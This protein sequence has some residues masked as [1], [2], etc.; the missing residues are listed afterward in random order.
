MNAR[1]HGITT[2]TVERDDERMENE[3]G[4]GIIVLDGVYQQVCR[5]DF[6]H[7]WIGRASGYADFDEGHVTARR[8]SSQHDQVAPASGQTLKPS[9]HGPAVQSGDMGI[10]AVADN[11]VAAPSTY[12]TSRARDNARP[13]ARDSET[14]FCTARRAAP[15]AADASCNVA[16][17]I[18]PASCNL[19]SAASCCGT[20]EATFYHD[21]DQSV[22]PQLTE[23]CPTSMSTTKL[24]CQLL[25][26]VDVEDLAM[27]FD[28]SM[29]SARPFPTS[30]RATYQ[31]RSRYGQS[32][33]TDQQPRQERR[34]GPDVGSAYD[35]GSYASRPCYTTSGD[36]RHCNSGLD[37]PAGALLS[38]D[39]A[40]GDLRPCDLGSGNLVAYGSDL[41]YVVPPC[42]AD[43]NDLGTG[44]VSQT[45]DLLSDGRS[46]IDGTGPVVDPRSCDTAFGGARFRHPRPCGPRFDGDP[47]ACAIT[48]GPCVM[49]EIHESG[50]DNNPARNNVGRG[51]LG[52][53]DWLCYDCPELFNF[54]S[55][56]R[57]LQ[58]P[59]SDRCPL[60]D[61]TSYAYGASALPPCMYE[62]LDT[63]YRVNDNWQYDY[64]KDEQLLEDYL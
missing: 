5:T 33:R 42:R 35:P 60:Y 34:V 6:R 53:G 22:A 29:D 44:R 13:C 58:C 39:I 56:E 9:S 15:C 43:F 61:T 62:N 50:R 59:A 4:G 63:G 3:V 57:W 21:D 16:R 64:T 1:L 19:A 54:C 36:P 24:N 14:T 30:N 45:H 25:G 23:I 10:S 47:R 31:K 11:N 38:A 52:P 12:V 7:H 20:I 51:D 37:D 40:A 26:P 27:C 32:A 28:P 48:A 55:E 8:V 18:A 2:A 41:V 17:N 46:S 49:Q